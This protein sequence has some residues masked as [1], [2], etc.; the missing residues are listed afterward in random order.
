[1]PVLG[2]A[3]RNALT[4]VDQMTETEWENIRIQNTQKVTKILADKC[5]YRNHT[6][7]THI[8]LYTSVFTRLYLSSF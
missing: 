1:M 5:T 6:K 7:H 8:H 4:S 3:Q 2:T